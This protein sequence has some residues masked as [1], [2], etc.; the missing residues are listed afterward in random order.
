LHLLAPIAVTHREVAEL[1]G[2]GSGDQ[3]S[4]KIH[5]ADPEVDLAHK[6]YKLSLVLVSTIT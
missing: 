2:V 3:D 5:L 1:P 6:Q 4:L